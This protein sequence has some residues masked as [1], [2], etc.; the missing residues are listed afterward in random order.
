MPPQLFPR[1]SNC[2]SDLFIGTDPDDGRPDHNVLIAC[3]SHE[4]LVLQ[5]L[6]HHVHP[7][8][9]HIRHEAHQLP[10]VSQQP[11]LD[12][13]RDLL[14][15]GRVG[16]LQ[17][18]CKGSGDGRGGEGGEGGEGGREGGREGGLFTHLLRSSTIFTGYTVHA[19]TPSCVLWMC[20]PPTCCMLTFELSIPPLML[21]LRAPLLTSAT[22][23]ARREGGSQFKCLISPN[24]YYVLSI[25]IFGGTGNIMMSPV[26]HSNS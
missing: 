5:H 18:A 4:H 26:Q 24:P 21:A 20:H 9:V 7:L 13:G 11:H 1:V 12:A 19:G 14:V 25:A 22:D 10:Q 3:Y 8:G 16:V 23:V 6:P 17:L 15:G 2:L